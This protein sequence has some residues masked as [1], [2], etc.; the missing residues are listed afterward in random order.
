MKKAMEL[1]ILTGADVGLMIFASNEKYFEYASN[2]LED[3]L[4]RYV[5]Q[6]TQSEKSLTNNDVIHPHI[7]FAF[8]FFLTFFSLL[9][10]L[11]ISHL[12]K[13]HFA[14]RPSK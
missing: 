6:D 9:F 11:E 14:V 1:S 4:V 8:F 3:I 5:E 13:A 10:F 2:S 12:L 7:S